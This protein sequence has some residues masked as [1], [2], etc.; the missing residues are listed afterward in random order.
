[1][2]LEEAK[3]VKTKERKASF[4]EIAGTATSGGTLAKIAPTA[5]KVVAP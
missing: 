5:P 1:M 2:D 3:A 4:R